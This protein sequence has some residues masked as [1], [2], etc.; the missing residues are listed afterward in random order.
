MKFLYLFNVVLIVFF[1]VIAIH[2]TSDLFKIFY[3]VTVICC[4]ILHWISI[5]AV[6]INLCFHIINDFNLKTQSLG[7]FHTLNGQRSLQ[8][9][10]FVLLE[11]LIVFFLNPLRV[12]SYLAGF[13]RKNWLYGYVKKIKQ[14]ATSPVS[15]H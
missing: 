8:A 13:G 12:D 14:T 3:W 10:F 6:L 11:I 1:I 2:F 5:H 4:L 7:C 9:L 15:P